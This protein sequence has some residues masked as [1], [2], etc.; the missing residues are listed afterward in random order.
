MAFFKK[1]TPEKGKPEPEALEE[2]EPIELEEVE[3][4]EEPEEVE[5]VEEVEEVVALEEVKEAPS[6]ALEL[7]DEPFDPDADDDE[8][9]EE[10][11]DDEPATDE[12]PTKQEDHSKEEAY[13]TVI[14]AE[15]HETIFALDKAVLNFGR[16]EK[17]NIVIPDKKASRKHFVIEMAGDYY[18]IIDAGSTNGTKVNGKKIAGTHRLREGDTMQVGQFKIVY[19]GPSDQP[20]ADPKTKI[21]HGEITELPEEAPAPKKKPTP[22]GPLPDDAVTCAECGNEM[23][24]NAPCECGYKS[25]KLR[26]QENFVDTIARGESILGGI[27]LWKLK[28]QKALDQAFA[29][30]DVA[31]V[32]EAV[33]DDC[34]KRHRTMNEFRVK[35]EKCECG[36]EISFPADD[37]PKLD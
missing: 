18:N 32:Q 9:E 3:P 29:M 23:P 27:G 33:C 25:L 5:A 11:D 20:P 16:D 24:E 1:K 34:G 7:D 13:V 4:I 14:D 37:P 2:A 35:C 19:H 22:Q 15:G 21:D 8:D 28:R 12:V 31:W 26:A 36:K 30:D 17:S 6:P 10:V